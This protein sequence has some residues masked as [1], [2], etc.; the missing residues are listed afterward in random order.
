M[1]CSSFIKMSVTWSINSKNK[2]SSLI[3]IL[4]HVS[5][6]YG[7]ESTVLPLLFSFN[8]KSRRNNCRFINCRRNRQVIASSTLQMT[9]FIFCRNASISGA[10]RTDKSTNG[11]CYSRLGLPNGTMSTN[12]A[13]GGSFPSFERSDLHLPNGNSN[14]RRARNKRHK[15]TKP[16]VGMAHAAKSP[17][18]KHAFH[19]L[20]STVLIV[21]WSVVDVSRYCDKC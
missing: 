12:A 9:D 19:E 16:P 14:V 17:Q 20:L 15:P 5:S 21:H 18:V 6:K 10:L 13:N 11:S 7:P 3:Q 2:N 4:N 1:K 8:R